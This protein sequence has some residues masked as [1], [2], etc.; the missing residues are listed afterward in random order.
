MKKI[1]PTS[2]FI[3]L[4][5]LPISASASE[6]SEQSKITEGGSVSSEGGTTQPAAPSP[7]PFAGSFA[8]PRKEQKAFEA[9][10]QDDYKAMYPD[11]SGDISYGTIDL[12]PAP[13]K[14]LQ[15]P[16]ISG[17]LTYYMNHVNTALQVLSIFLMS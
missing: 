1:I 12:K 7:G 4:F 10:I 2:L 16:I 13:P 15:D 8:D 11:Y 17:K 14:E 9:P 6:I 5:F 3:L